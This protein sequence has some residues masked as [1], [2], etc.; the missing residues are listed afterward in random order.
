MIRR[1]PRS[2][3]TDTLF[4]YTTLFRSKRAEIFLVKLLLIKWSKF[5]HQ[6][7]RKVAPPVFHL[8]PKPGLFW[9]KPPY[10]KLPFLSAGI[11]YFNRNPIT[12]RILRIHDNRHFFFVNIAKTKD[13]SSEILNDFQR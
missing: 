11:K 1:P 7:F 13:H 4:P 5:L 6:H 12:R 8:Y 3:R 2:T 9:R 10:S